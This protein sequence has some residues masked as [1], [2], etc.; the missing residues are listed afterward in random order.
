MQSLIQLSLFPS[1]PPP[2]PPRDNAVS[3]QRLRKRSVVRRLC[4]TERWLCINIFV[5]IV[6]FVS[7]ESRC[8]EHRFFCSAQALCTVLQQFYLTATS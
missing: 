5:F 2:P 7:V 6:A 8:T 3:I 4:Q 1:P